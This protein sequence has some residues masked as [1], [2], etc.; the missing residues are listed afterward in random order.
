MFKKYELENIDTFISSFNN[1]ALGNLIRISDEKQEN[2][3]AICV[4]NGNRKVGIE[5]TM[6]IL[7]EEADPNLSRA[8]YDQRLGY[9]PMP[10]IN[11][12][13]SRIRTKSINDYKDQDIEEIWLV[14]SGGSFISDH[15]LDDTLRETDL[16]KKFDRIFIS[17]GIYSGFAEIKLVDK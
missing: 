6:V 14:I 17:Q 7:P 4:L 8:P 3:D 11:Q 5:E 9:N 12:V 10:I 2:P 13:I 16:P 15:D 1:V